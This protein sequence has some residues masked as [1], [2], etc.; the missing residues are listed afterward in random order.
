MLGGGGFAC[1][2]VGSRAKSKGNID[3]SFV[4]QVRSV[5]TAL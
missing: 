1:L 2:K 4:M 5:P 3:R